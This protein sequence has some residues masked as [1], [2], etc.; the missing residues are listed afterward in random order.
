MAFAA[1]HFRM[2][3]NIEEGIDEE[4]FK[5]MIMKVKDQ[6]TQLETSDMVVRR[7]VGADQGQRTEDAVV[8]ALN[9]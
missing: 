8:Q 6:I 7:L 9:S 4:A 5:R 1:D 2:F 3:L